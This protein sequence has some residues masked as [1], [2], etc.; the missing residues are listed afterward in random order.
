MPPET[1]VNITGLAIGFTAFALAGYWYL[2]EHSFD[3][4]HPEWK[5]TYAITTSG[6]SKTSTGEDVE[7]NQLHESDA[8][9]LMSHPFVE[10]SCRLWD[11]WGTWSIINES[12][13]KERFY[14]FNVDSAFFSVFHADFLEGN[15]YR[16]PCNNEYVVLTRSAAMRLFSSTK[17]VG[18]VIKLN[19]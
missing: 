2:W 16:I 3:T 15:V 18:E 9:V 8:K 19:N 5:R 11:T 4:F 12:D 17:C 7:M 14:G 1:W 6:N 13:Q 10:K